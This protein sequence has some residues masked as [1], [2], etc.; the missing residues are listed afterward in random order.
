MRFSQRGQQCFY[1]HPLQRRGTS[2]GRALHDK[3]SRLGRARC[4]RGRRGGRPRRRDLV[5]LVVRVRGRPRANS[6]RGPDRSSTVRAFSLRPPIWRNSLDAGQWRSAIAI[7]KE[8]FEDEPAL[9]PLQRTTAGAAI[10]LLLRHDRVGLEM[11]QLIGRTAVRTIEMHSGRLCHGEHLSGTPPTVAQK[12]RR[13]KL[14][15][16][17]TLKSSSATLKAAIPK[18]RRS[19]Q[20]AFGKLGQSGIQISHC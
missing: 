7:Y 15:S 9:A 4:A 20:T 8:I 6:S 12:G 13:F 11:H 5:R 2:L 1:T 14:G 16:A 17:L 19:N 18:A 3:A 10:E